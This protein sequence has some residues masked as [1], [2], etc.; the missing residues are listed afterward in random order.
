M[1]LN[2]M[3]DLLIEI[4]RLKSLKVASETEGYQLVLKALEEDWINISDELGR[5][6]T[7]ANHITLVAKIAEMQSIKN[8][9]KSM[10]VK[11]EDIKTLTDE[12]NKLLK[13]S[14]K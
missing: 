6:Y 1:N 12:Y 8:L 14:K 13:E 9:I 3:E 10:I 5:I 2:N 11:D 7:E 4:N